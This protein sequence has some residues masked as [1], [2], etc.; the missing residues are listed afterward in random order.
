MRGDGAGG[1]AGG[2][3]GMPDRKLHPRVGVT[4]LDVMTI[5]I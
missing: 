4:N 2:V 5:R 3:T 1:R